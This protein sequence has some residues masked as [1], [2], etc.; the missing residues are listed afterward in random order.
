MCGLPGLEY[1]SVICKQGNQEKLFPILIPNDIGI[2]CT[3]ESISD[4]TGLVTSK[5]K[6]KD[7]T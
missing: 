7:C 5:K 4:M 2:N 6:K 3:V 1:S